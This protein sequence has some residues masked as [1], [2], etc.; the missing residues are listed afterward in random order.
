[1]RTSFIISEADALRVTRREVNLRTSSIVSENDALRVTRREWNSPG[2][3]QNAYFVEGRKV[4]AYCHFALGEVHRI[5]YEI[6]PVA[7]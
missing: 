7:A 3:L 5:R 4:Q 2:F 6:L 1:M